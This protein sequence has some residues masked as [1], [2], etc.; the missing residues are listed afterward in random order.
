MTDVDTPAQSIVAPPNWHLLCVAASL[1]ALTTGVYGLY[2]KVDRQ[3]DPDPPRHVIVISLDTAR[4]DHFG[5][6]G[7]PSIRT[8]EIDAL[9]AESVLFTDYMTV[10]PTTLA[11]HVSLF[12]GKY[13]HTHGTPRNGFVVNPE[14]VMLPEILREAGFHTAG[15]AGSFSLD[16]RFGFAQ[17]FEHYDEAFDHLAGD[18]GPDQN[19][20]SAQAVTDAVI[21]HLEKTGA[22]SRLF[23]FAHYFDPHAPYVPPPPFDTMYDPRGRDGLPDATTIANLCRR[24]PGHEN[25]PAKRLALQYAGEISYMD[26]H[27]GRLLDYL[28]E[29]GI[30]DEAVLIVVSDHGENFWE[31]PLYFDHGLTTYRA[32]MRC[33]CLIRLPGAR[34]AGTKVDRL[35]A[36]IDIL[37]T[38]LDLL[39]LPGRTD[40][41]G[42]A[43]DLL[44]I[45]APWPPRVRFGQASKPWQKVETDPRWYN[46]RK[47]RCVRQGSLEYIHTPFA[48]TE[49][50]YDLSVDPQE[51]RNLL[52]GASP[53]VQA[54]A[55]RLRRML[56]AWAQS[57]NPLPSRFEPSQ[58]NETI[59]RLRSL[60][61]LEDH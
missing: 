44:R 48:Q 8:P 19:Q 34:H 45:D 46:L 25:P 27:A 49:E 15:F 43:M 26:K 14:N 59:R 31:H 5:C 6:Y 42:E 36:S 13:P 2:R 54:E 21:E 16:T 9:A 47:A 61:Y 20:R 17:G 37:P 40:L 30:L 57:A 18:L 60:G 11:S 50:L 28:R 12:T 4:A 33:V 10:V 24:N 56:D 1:V 32:T 41:D 53:E 35:V 23:L 22:A 39:G 29:R 52:V 55:A 51:R 3:A 7:H 58:V 38:V